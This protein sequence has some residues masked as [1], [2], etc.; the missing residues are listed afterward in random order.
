MARRN[1]FGALAP[2]GVTRCGDARRPT[3]GGRARTRLGD[4]RKRGNV[5]DVS[6]WANG[7]MSE[8]A[9]ERMGE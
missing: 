5:G 4:R 9:N 7:R 2:E 6:E 1:G 3:R 8:W